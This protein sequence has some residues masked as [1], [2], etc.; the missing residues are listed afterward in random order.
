MIHL[1]FSIVVLG[2][3]YSIIRVKKVAEAWHSWEDVPFV[4][5]GIKAWRISLIIIL[6]VLILIYF[7]FV[8]GVIK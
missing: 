1:I 3:L 5:K 4:P 6:V 2:L 7:L 8:F